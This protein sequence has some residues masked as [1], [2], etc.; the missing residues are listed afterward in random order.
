[1]LRFT[2]DEYVVFFTWF[3]QCFLRVSTFVEGC[4]SV[5]VKS[6]ATSST[7]RASGPNVLDHSPQEHPPRD[8]HTPNLTRASIIT[9]RALSSL[10]PCPIT[11]I[12]VVVKPGIP[13][14]HSNASG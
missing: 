5:Q 9:H 4:P 3:F 12:H 10:V 11:L 14:A 2:V 8:H 6:Y 1:M 7:T 13:E